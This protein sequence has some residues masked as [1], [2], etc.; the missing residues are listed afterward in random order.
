MCVQYVCN[1]CVFAWM[2]CALIDL[3]KPWRLISGLLNPHK[4]SFLSL[5]HKEIPERRSDAL[6]FCSFTLSDPPHKRCIIRSGNDPTEVWW[7]KLRFCF[8][9]PS[10]PSYQRMYDLTH[11]VSCRPNLKGFKTTNVTEYLR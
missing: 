1:V 8:A 5:F 3:K 7:S 4:M 6:G 10:L 11:E 9:S 2:T